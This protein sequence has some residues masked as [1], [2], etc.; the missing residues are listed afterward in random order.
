[1][2]RHLGAIALALLLAA[3]ASDPPTLVTLPPAPEPTASL[4]LDSP[5]STRTPSLLLR[6]VRVPG[7]LDGLPVVLR[8]DGGELVVS[9][10]AEWAERL[11]TAST[12]VLRDALAVRLGSSRLLIEGDGRIPDA[13]L[14]V[15]VLHMDPL[16]DGRLLL[17]ARWSFV[18]SAGDRPTRAGRASVTARMR[19]ET[20]A[21]VATATGE[22]IGLLAD[23]LAEHARRLSQPSEGAA[24]GMEIRVEGRPS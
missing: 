4:G 9:R 6:P 5:A 3:C 20:P 11:G 1:M 12:R 15:E 16:P 7:Y 13:D 19:G 24:R 10:E 23:E 21:H 18:G 14:S 2:A 8:R 17:E 22:A